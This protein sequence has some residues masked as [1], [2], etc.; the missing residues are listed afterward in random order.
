[1]RAQ[2]IL[3]AIRRASST[4][5]ALLRHLASVGDWHALAALVAAILAH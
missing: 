5:R 2:Q 4:E 3:A 1:M